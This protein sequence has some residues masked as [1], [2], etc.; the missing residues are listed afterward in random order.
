MSNNNANQTNNRQNDNEIDLIQLFNS[1]GISIKKLFIIIQKLLLSALYFILRNFIVLIAIIS[2]GIAINYFTN[3]LNSKPK[4]PKKIQKSVFNSHMIVKT[5]IIP[6]QI[7]INYINKLGEL[8]KKENKSILTEELNIDSITASKITNI[9]AFWFID[10]NKDGIAD[11]IDFNNV[12]LKSTNDTVS[13]RIENYF[14]IELKY[15]ETIDVLMISK[16]LIDYINKNPYFTK[17]NEL[18]KKYLSES[19]HTIELELIKIDKIQENYSKKNYLITESGK[20][21]NLSSKQIYD[22]EEIKL[23]QNL[24]FSLEDKKQSVLKQLELYPDIVTIIEN[25][26]PSKVPILIKSTNNKPINKSAHSKYSYI[27][28]L[29]GIIGILIFENRKKI[30]ELIKESKK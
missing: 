3:F 15:T 10:K 29:L 14:D 12:S 1:I 21:I 8:T 23:Q 26:T 24:I 17:A 25:F 2:I 22:T 11:Y 7:I 27:F 20:L 16:K 28:I 5:N 9:A 4:I 19:Y 13:G 6:N 18:R 30:A